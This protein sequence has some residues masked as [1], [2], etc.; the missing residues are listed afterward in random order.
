[1]KPGT[2]N[3]IVKR[4]SGKNGR[5]S[6][7][8]LFRALL[9]KKEGGVAI[10]AALAVPLFIVLLMGLLQLAIIVIAYITMQDI[11]RDTA[12]E[13]ALRRVGTQSTGYSATGTYTG[14]CPDG[15]TVPNSAQSMACSRLGGYAGSYDVFVDEEDAAGDAVVRLDVGVAD[16]LFFNVGFL[17][18]DGTLTAEA[19]YNVEDRP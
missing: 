14:T 16:L 4:P 18:T 6:L 10:E 5:R 13:V 19:R 8:Q 7:P 15:L 11:V 3:Q 1:M 17:G 2:R 9:R 12:R